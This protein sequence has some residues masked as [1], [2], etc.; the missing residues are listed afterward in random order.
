MLVLSF[1]SIIHDRALCASCDGWG[2][3]RAVRRLFPDGSLD[4][5]YF[6]MYNEP[7]GCSRGNTPYFP[8][9]MTAQTRN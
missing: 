9:L 7:A 3:R 8:T 6:P 4:E 2:V 5:I 1:Y